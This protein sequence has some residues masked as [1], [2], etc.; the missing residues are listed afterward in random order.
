MKK[1]VT[2]LFLSLFVSAFGQSKKKINEQL[3]L[4]LQQKVSAYDS[5][6]NAQLEL[7]GKISAM[8][9]EIHKQMRVVDRLRSDEFAKRSILYENHRMLKGLGFNAD[10]LV[11][12][13]E[14][15]AQKGPAID[16]KASYRYEMRKKS[17]PM[18]ALEPIQDLTDVK[19][20]VQNELFTK[21]INEYDSINLLN[22]AKQQ[23]AVA[24]LSQLTD[25][26]NEYIRIAELHTAFNKEL[27]VK[28]DLLAN[29]WF[30]VNAKQ[31]EEARVEYEKEIKKLE[32]YQKK[33]KNEL[34]FIPPRIIDYEPYNERE[35]RKPVLST[36]KILIKDRSDESDWALPEPREI[37]EPEPPHEEVIMSF[38]EEEPEFP[39]GRE[40]MV[41]YLKDN[42]VLPAKVV[43][44]EVSGRCY[45]RFV[46]SKTGEISSMQV[47]RGVMD[48]KECD[49]EAVRVVKAMPAWIPG[50]NNGKPVNM[51]YNLPISFKQQ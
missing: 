4:E 17:F 31:E 42:L 32:A 27:E 25:I 11:S 48:C 10:S 44:G 23:E 30:E 28:G 46:V 3:K 21:K 51:Y 41:K 1:L 26:N 40:A 36:D 2:I 49:D 33:H 43:S 7:D 20:K 29:K 39:G 15:S 14:I 34:V 8:Q 47:T 45:L 22:N 38:V 18:L 9:S 13:K 5:L 6:R 37:K 19:V 12:K 35:I 24:F 16:P 50:K